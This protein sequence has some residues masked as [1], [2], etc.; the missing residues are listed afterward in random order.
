MKPELDQ[1]LQLGENI[2]P[3]SLKYYTFDDLFHELCSLYAKNETLH[4]DEYHDSKHCFNLYKQMIED[5]DT[6]WLGIAGIGIVEG[7]GSYVIDLVE[8]GF[9]DVICSTGAQVY[10][11]LHF[12]YGLPVKRINT[13]LISREY[14]ILLRNK[15]YARIYDAVIESKA[16]LMEQDKIICAFVQD[17]KYQKLLTSREISSAEFNYL[18]GKYVLETAPYPERS[19]VAACAKHYVPLFWDSMQNHSIAMNLAKLKLDGINVRL[20]AQDDINLS[21]AIVY[22]SK[23]SGF[24]LLGGGGPKNFIQQTSPTITQILNIDWEGA[25]R[26]LQITT[27]DV[28]DGGLSGCKL[29]EGI[30][31]EKYGIASKTLQIKGDYR[32]RFGLAALLAYEECEQRK[33]KE[34]LKPKNP[35][36]LRHCSQELTKAYKE[37]KRLYG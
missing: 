17:K 28:K 29:E 18:L 8:R 35:N 9:I 13:D 7:Q 33:L 23:S 12:A 14:D 25:D 4:D 11:D 24:F 10:H 2:I 5:N 16:T 6:I 22:C 36:N 27:A 3:K 1:K 31:W 20:S 32:T 26:G 37:Q 19:F 30:S 34:F 21:A 15:G